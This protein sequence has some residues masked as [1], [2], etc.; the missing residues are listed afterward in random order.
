M[1]VRPI[2]A[3]IGRPN[4]GKSTLFNRLLKKRQAIVS[5]VSGTTRDRLYSVVNFDGLEADIVDTA[6]LTQ[7]LEEQTFGLEML[8]QAQL[9]VCEANLLIFVLDA[10][11]GLTHEDKELANIIRKA[12]TPCVVYVNKYDNPTLPLDPDFLSLGIGE[13][14]AGSL[15]QR[16]GTDS[17]VESIATILKP[18]A[19]NQQAE[20]DRAI[21]PRVTLAGRVNVGKSTLFN[22]LVGT[23]RVIVSD[24]PGTTRDTIDTEITLGNG[25]R[26]IITDTAGLR[27]KGKIGRAGKIEQYSVLRTL[28]AIDQA[29]LVLLVVDATEGLTRGDIHV[30]TYALEQKKRLITVLNKIDLVDSKDVNVCR[31]PFLTKHPMVFV[32]AKEQFATSELLERVEESLRNL[33]EKPDQSSRLEK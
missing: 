27:R 15:T 30:A 13:V 22:V 5:P 26:F 4:V 7:D 28:R 32:S 25:Q 3:I 10:Q 33:G 9:A 12:E 20:F 14:I 1:S 2:V 18:M 23:D 17:L 8:E 19:T 21:C 31:F 6:G 16:R 11:Y 24:I 29:D